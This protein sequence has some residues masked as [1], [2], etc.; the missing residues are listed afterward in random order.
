M[1]EYKREY[2]LF[3]LCGLNCGL[4]PRYQSKSASRCPGCGGEEFHLKH[5]SCAIITCSRKHG[6]VEY[7]FQCAEYPCGRYKQTS[8]SDSF[9][10]YQNVLSDFEKARAGL[11]DYRRELNEKVKFLELLIENYNDGRRTSFY[12][13]AV[14]LLNPDDLSDIKSDISARKDKSTVAQKEKLAMITT[15]F[16]KKAAE[17]GI[18][19]K[20]RK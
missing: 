14:N 2:P 18:N 9:I 19:L 3:S 15:A 20:L 12:C 6:D 1:K 17:K 13:N 4:C 11:E 10:S 7:C 5:P 8:G 16:E